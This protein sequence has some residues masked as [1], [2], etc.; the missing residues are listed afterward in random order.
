MIDHGQEDQNVI[1]IGTVLMK[2]GIFWSRFMSK[3]MMPFAIFE[4]QIILKI[5]YK[6]L[7]ILRGIGSNTIISNES[8]NVHGFSSAVKQE[9]LSRRSL[10]LSASIR[11]SHSP[12]GG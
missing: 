11:R 1:G 9:T 4:G 12:N 7:I 8:Q 5:L 10:Q 6:M 2:Q 3:S